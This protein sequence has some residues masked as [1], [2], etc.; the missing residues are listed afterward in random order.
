MTTIDSLREIYSQKIKEFSTQLNKLESKIRIVSYSRLTIALTSIVIFY[1]ALTENPYLFFGLLFL[2][3][4]FSILVIIHSS[5]FRKKE[6]TENYIKIN[7]NEL[8]Y[9]N[10]DF[11]S[12]DKG[13]D[14]IDFNHPYTYDLDI[15]GESSL[16]QSLCRTVTYQGRIILART[17]SQPLLSQSGILSRQACVKEL[18]NKLDFRQRFQ[19]NGLLLKDTDNETLT[20]WLH[21]QYHFLNQKFISYILVALPLFTIASLLVS[22]FKQSIHPLFGLSIIINGIVYGANAKKINALFSMVSRK[23]LLLESYAHLMKIVYDEK[24]KAPELEE[25]RV[26]LQNGS[27]QIRKLAGY[28]GWF[29]QRLNFPFNIALNSLFLFDLQCCYRIEKWRSW[30]DKSIPAWLNTLGNADAIFSLSNF[31]YNNPGFS[32]PE[33]SEEKLS[34][35]AKELSHPLIAGNK[36][37]PNDF[38]LGGGNSIGIVTGANMAGKS[39]F[40]R[41]LGI[42]MVLV[43]TGAPVCAKVFKIPIIDL[44][45]GM[46]V[47]D[48]LKDDVSYFYAELQKLKM[49]RTMAESGQPILILLDEMLRGTNSKDKQQGS[50]AFMEALLNFNC[51]SLLATHDIMLGKMEEE[52]P[53]R[54]KNFCF[55]GLIRNDELFFDYKI[56]NGIAQ[57]TNASFLMRKLG[58]I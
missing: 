5:L 25:L 2:L 57:N 46:R 49:I 24:F 21:E 44:V 52:Y 29:D 8:K 56:K 40:L 3:I 58:I 42:N 12:F 53:L 22:V 13:E 28:T 11:S 39:T 27:E 4:L 23:K 10:H 41:T 32:F 7:E 6:L 16:F 18:K 26:S 51:L 17:M 36:R 19:A 50:K 35:H 34:I 20:K 1:F 14:L 48:S 15:F 33:F 9:L 47:S 38:D 54:I 31:A 43:Y 55:E 45:S 37:V 30:N